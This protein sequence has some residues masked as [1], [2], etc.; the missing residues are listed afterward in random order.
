M[1]LFSC[2]CFR[3]AELLLLLLCGLAVAALL[4]FSQ[5]CCYCAV[6]DAS[7]TGVG[8]PVPAAQALWVLQS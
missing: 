1:L 4:M 5:L 3:V 8:E 6:A 2:C 7:N